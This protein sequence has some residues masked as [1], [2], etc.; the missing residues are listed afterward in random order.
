M[1]DS[2]ETYYVITANRLVEGDV[3]YMA[4]HDS[5][6]NWTSDIAK[7]DTFPT[8]ERG[9]AVLLAE[10]SVNANVV[11]G[12]YAVEIMGKN[13]PLGTKEKIR[14]EG[15]TIAHSGQP[16]PATGPDYSI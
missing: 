12:A 9:N 1:A 6:T 11:V 14:S 10:E 5:K 2:Q 3:V 16:R 7:A 13:E 8:D 15:P 4:R